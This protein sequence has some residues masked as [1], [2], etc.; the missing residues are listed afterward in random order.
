M[1]KII[2]LIVF[3]LMMSMTGCFD[4]ESKIYGSWIT[5]HKI[6]GEYEYFIFFRNGTYHTNYFGHYFVRGKFVINDNTIILEYKENATT[7]EMTYGDETYNILKIKYDDIVTV[8]K[9]DT[10]V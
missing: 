2:I 7:V 8:F 4:Y 6:D 9:R 10:T 3:F 1:K 5:E